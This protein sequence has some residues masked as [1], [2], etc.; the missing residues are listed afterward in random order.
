MEWIVRPKI[1]FKHKVGNMIFGLIKIIDGIILFILLGN[2]S[3][4]FGLNFT[5]L[6][7]RYKFLLDN[8]KQ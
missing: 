6:R 4:Q 3:T 1:G 5:I 2:L 8:K 7:S